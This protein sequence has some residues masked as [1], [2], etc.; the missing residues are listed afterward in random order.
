MCKKGINIVLESLSVLIYQI[1]ENAGFDAK[2]GVYVNL[3][4]KGIID[5]TR[6]N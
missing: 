1:A 5:P 4:Q 6:T 3:L 2:E